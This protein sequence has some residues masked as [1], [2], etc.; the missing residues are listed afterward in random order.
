[1]NANDCPTIT[2]VPESRK[3][4]GFLLNICKFCHKLFTRFWQNKSNGNDFLKT[5]YKD[6]INYKIKCNFNDFFLLFGGYH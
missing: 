6:N 2:S 5:I 4:W 1:M 3:K